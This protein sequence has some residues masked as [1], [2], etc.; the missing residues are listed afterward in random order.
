MDGRFARDGR[1]ARKRS[2][3]RDEGKRRRAWRRANARTFRD[4]RAF[5]HRAAVVAPTAATRFVVCSFWHLGRRDVEVRGARR[6]RKFARATFRRRAAPPTLPS[7]PFRLGGGTH[8]PARVTDVVVHRRA[9]RARRAP[10]EPSRRF[11]SRPR[12]RRPRRHHREERH[13]REHR[14]H[15]GG[16]AARVRDGPR[17]PAP[18]RSSTGSTATRRRAI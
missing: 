1:R 13:H 4:V 17:G 3:R 9:L 12:A 16:K 15:R 5:R 7:R 11:P 18:R 6:K 8:R 10:I 14:S 2:P